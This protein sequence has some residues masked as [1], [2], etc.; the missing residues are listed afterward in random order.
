MLGGKFMIPFKFLSSKSLDKN[1]DILNIVLEFMH[2]FEA[3][4]NFKFNSLFSP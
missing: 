1:L 3:I 4:Q 2:G